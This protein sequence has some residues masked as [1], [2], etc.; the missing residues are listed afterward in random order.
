VRPA[1]GTIGKAS[2]PT[3]PPAA[4]VTVS[5]LTVSPGLAAPVAGTPSPVAVRFSLSAAAAPKVQVVGPD[6]T[7]LTLSAAPLPAGAS[8]VR[9]D[10]SALPDGAYTVRVSSGSSLQT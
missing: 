6:G 3:A 4:P 5:G 7:V 8:I 1:V 2:L 9:F 10:A